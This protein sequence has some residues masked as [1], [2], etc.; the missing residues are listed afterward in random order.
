MANV[1]TEEL[2]LQ[3]AVA[4]ARE[5]VRRREV[6]SADDVRRQLEISDEEVLRAEELL[7]VRDELEALLHDLDPSNEL[8][9]VSRTQVH[10]WLD[11][12]DRVI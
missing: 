1:R 7:S 5:Q 6:L 2:T 9:T 12:L 10:R 3:G 4:H 11:T 8:V